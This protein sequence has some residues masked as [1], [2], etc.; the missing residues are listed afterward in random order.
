MD[1][2]RIVNLMKASTRVLLAAIAAGAI[3]L[4]AP[5]ATVA[6]AVCPPPGTLAE[7][8][9]VDADQ[10]G[11]LTEAFPPIYGPY[12]EGAAA[13]WP[14]QEIVVTAFVS[15]PEGLGGTRSFTIEPAWLVSEA[16]FLSASATVDPESGPVGPFLPVAVP[17]ALEGTFTAL[18][19]HW[20]RASG[21][22]D[23]EV[24]QTCVVAEGDPDAGA[25]AGA[26]N[27]DLSDVLRAHS[28]RA[29]HDAEYR[30]CAIGAV[31]RC[32]TWLACPP[33]GGGD[34]G[35]VRPVPPALRAHPRHSLIASRQT[36]REPPSG[37]VGS[38][39]RGARSEDSWIVSRP[40]D[41]AMSGSA[42]L[43]WTG[44]PRSRARPG[45]P[46]IFGGRACCTL[47]SSLRCMPTRAS[48]GSFAGRRSR[49]L[50]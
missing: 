18:A 9:A 12:A 35:R 33:A 49:S 37:D 22:F 5:A 10:H 15:S 50:A 21:H 26:G 39:P 17:P 16:H 7:I 34:G 48:F 40:S 30:R 2:G 24:A 31:R 47:G 42:G 6:S 19:G 36:R 44:F 41:N 14:G 28:R 38:I 25:D 20:V 4:A 27:P 46:Q 11:P 32:A 45:T 3:H 23:D 13:C 29:T 8:I 43:E 1:G